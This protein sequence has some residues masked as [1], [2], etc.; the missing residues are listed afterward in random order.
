MKNLIPKL[1]TEKIVKVRFY[2]YD[3]NNKRVLVVDG[4]ETYKSIGEAHKD[5]SEYKG[6]VQS[7]QNIAK[8]EKVKGI[9]SR[10]LTCYSN[11]EVPKKKKVA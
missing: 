11:L 9:P 3:L 8:S 10:V 2:G 5:F 6:L 7:I 1:E 4:T